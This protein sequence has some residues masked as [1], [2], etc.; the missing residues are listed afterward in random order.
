MIEEAKTLQIREI[1]T[2]DLDLLLQLY[3]HLHNNKKPQLNENI[4]NIWNDILV[5][6]YHHII[7]GIVAGQ[8][9][10]SC[11]MVIVPNLTNDQR[12]YALIENVITH[13]DYRE[14]GYA[15][16]LLDY[17]KKIAD[18]EN[19]YKIMLMTGAKDKKTLKFYEHAGFNRKDKTAFI[20]WF[21]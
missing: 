14:R 13:P 1:E 10:S 21:K 3:T 18:K 7:V 19:S 8:I 11:V 17:A 2:D 15:T 5:N 12:P 6:D 16:R 9:V 4:K 20:R